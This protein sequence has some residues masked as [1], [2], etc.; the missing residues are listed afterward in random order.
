[1]LEVTHTLLILKIVMD[2]P[3][4]KK[5]TFQIMQ[6]Y[7]IDIISIQAEQQQS[8]SVMDNGSSNEIHK[9]SGDDLGGTKVDALFTS[10]LADIFCNDVM[11][12]ISSMNRC[13]FFHLWKDFEVK[14][15]TI[16]PNL[17]D[18]VTL[19]LPARLSDTFCEKN[20]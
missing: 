11:E 2:F 14:K 5:K 6:M 7:L 20:P 16:C 8:Q 13:N 10:P 1:M 9:A 4:L 12:S 3:S 18:F 17:N 15:R 19:T